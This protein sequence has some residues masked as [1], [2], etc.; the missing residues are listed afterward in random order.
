MSQVCKETN[1]L[2]VVM[3]KTEIPEW[4]DHRNKGGIP[5]FR[6]R[7]K[8]PV[9]ALAFVFE[10]VNAMAKGPLPVHSECPLRLEL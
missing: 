10:E 7:G 4:F 2:E 8:F 5:V 6:A 9:V 1:K 3:P